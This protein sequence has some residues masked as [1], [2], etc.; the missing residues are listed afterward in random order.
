MKSKGNADGLATLN[1]D[2]KLVDTQL[3]AIHL[4]SLGD[5]NITSVSNGEVLSYN[6]ETQKWVN[7]DIWS[8]NDSIDNGLA[9]G[10]NAKAT[11]EFARQIRPGTNSSTKTLNFLGYRLLDSDG[12]IPNTRIRG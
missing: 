12:R 10:P 1:L 3:P 8:G 2:G 11:A 9:F 5:T 7:K 6:L 4:V